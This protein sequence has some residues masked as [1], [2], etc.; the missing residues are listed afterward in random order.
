MWIEK[1]LLS[2]INLMKSNPIKANLKGS[3]FR[4]NLYRKNTKHAVFYERYLFGAIF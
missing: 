2:S 3:K 1:L 4:P